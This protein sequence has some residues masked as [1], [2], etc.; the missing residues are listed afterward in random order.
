MIRKHAQKYLAIAGPHTGEIMTGVVTR[1]CDCGSC[2]KCYTPYRQ[3]YQ[4]GDKFS[5]PRPDDFLDQYFEKLSDYPTGQEIFA[6]ALK[7][8]ITVKR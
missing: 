5:G 8:G 7:H 6:L 4:R 1:L 2:L 3:L